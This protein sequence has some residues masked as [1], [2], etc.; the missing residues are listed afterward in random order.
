[1]GGG[2]GGGGGTG[3]GAGS[4][5]NSNST[6][7]Q[8]SN[9]QSNA[10]ASGTLTAA[11]G[12]GL[13][14]GTLNPALAAD[15]GGGDARV[16]LTNGTATSLQLPNGQTAQ[17]GPPTTNADST[18]TSSGTTGD[19]S[20]VTVTSHRTRSNLSYSD[21]GTW[22]VAP[23]GGPAG[24]AVYAVGSPTPLTAVPTTGSAT[25]LGHAAGTAS[26]GGS[27][28][29]FKGNT[30]L[31]ANF[32]VGSINGQITGLQATGAG[33]APAGS[34][35]DIALAGSI[36]GNGFAGTALPGP[37]GSLDIG[38]T[39]GSFGGGF[40]GP[41]AEEASGTFKMEGGGDAVI[42]SFGARR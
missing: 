33:G 14:T 1:G 10:S 42:G 21:Y 4:V 20:V 23:T 19:G 5:S 24:V 26:L 3:A 32:A 28:Y 40:A 34:M 31:T 9:T 36:N 8:N 41:N 35:N 16:S 37:A 18:R 17:L 25:Y 11:R 2:G 6:S 7:S 38:H 30:Q 15:A 22:A 12:R 39:S 13:E 29:S 27:N